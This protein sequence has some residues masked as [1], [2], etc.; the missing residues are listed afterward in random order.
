MKLNYRR[1]A[2]GGASV[3]LLFYAI[4]ILS[5][6]G[7]N[8][9]GIDWDFANTGQF[10]DSFG[11]LSTFMAAVAAVSALG[12]YLSQKEELKRVRESS[13]SER[14]TTE[15]RDFENTFFNL[16]KL[17][18]DTV[19]EVDVTDRY[20]KDP[21]T[22]RDAMR[23]VLDDYVNHYRT[24]LGDDRK[25]F[26]SAYTRFKDDLAHYFRLFYHILRFVDESPIKNKMLYVRLLRATLSDA[27]IVLIALNCMH[28]GGAKLKP[29]VEKYA[30]LHNVS[31]SS[32]RTWHIIGPFDGG[33]FGDRSMTDDETDS[34]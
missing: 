32:A 21:L 17:F 30:I 20:G 12:A 18:R 11:P 2:L 6:A 19:T 10:G 1:I 29:L 5:A 15:K 22:G 14:E 25:A 13:A 34:D 16:L 4:V 9:T 33:A 23:R 28:G 3:F 7:W 24:K 26:Q 27:E 8:P 31:L